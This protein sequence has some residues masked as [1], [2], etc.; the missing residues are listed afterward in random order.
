MRLLMLETRRGSEDG[1][2]V[3]RFHKNHHYDIA[4]ALA[5]VFLRSKAAQQISKVKGQSAIGFCPLTFDI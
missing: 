1:F 3:R 2:A 5:R 4:D